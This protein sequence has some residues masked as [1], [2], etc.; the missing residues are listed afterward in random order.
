MGAELGVP[1]GEKFVEAGG[2]GFVVESS[3][4]FELEDIAEG[5]EGVGV[6]AGVH[7]GESLPRVADGRN[8]MEEKGLGR[9]WC[10]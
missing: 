6:L 9:H 3:F 2:D 7:D 1:A 4:V 10:G 5:V 8:M